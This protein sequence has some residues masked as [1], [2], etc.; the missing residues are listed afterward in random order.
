MIVAD[1]LVRTLVVFLPWGYAM[2]SWPR[3]NLAS[4]AVI[5]LVTMSLLAGC[6]GSRSPAASPPH[7]STIK[8]GTPTSTANHPSTPNRSGGNPSSSNP[9][10]DK[11]ST[12]TQPS[13]KPSTPKHPSGGNPPPPNPGSGKPSPSN[14]GSGKPAPPPAD[15]GFAWAPWGPADTTAPPPKQWYG[16]LERV[17]EN[18][19]EL[20]VYGDG[21]GL[22]PALLAVCRAAVEDTQSQW[23]VAVS[24]AKELGEP[25]EGVPACMEQAARALLRRALAWHERNPD[26][27]PDVQF[28]TEGSKPVCDFKIQEVRRAAQDLNGNWEAV[29]GLLEGR[30]TDNTPLALIGRGIDHPKEAR[31]AGVSVKIEDWRVDP[32]SLVVEVFVR[33][34]KVDRAPQAAS[35]YLRNR[36]GELLAPATFQ[37]T[38]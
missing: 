22:W 21:P 15:D 9:S 33:T 35:I 10:T 27:Q 26:R 5:L 18:C 4:V 11:P 3:P 16:R 2:R 24:A 28:P 29:G 25:T 37:Y 20:E 32:D 36:A 23:A 1:L 12:P 6:G 13:T 7:P 8:P 19:N 17:R 34:P 30:T 31:I 38:D 14:P